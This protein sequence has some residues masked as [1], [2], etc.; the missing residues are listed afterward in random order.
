MPAPSKGSGNGAEIVDLAAGDASG[1]ALRG[2]LT[3]QTVPGLWRQSSRLFGE[4][5]ETLSIDLAGVT[6]ADSAGLA[7]LITWAGQ[8]LLAKVT[9]RYAAVPERLLSLARISEVEDLLL[10]AA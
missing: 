3:A 2:E 5:R 6:E 1:L 4:S 9:L 8:A 10:P 7:L